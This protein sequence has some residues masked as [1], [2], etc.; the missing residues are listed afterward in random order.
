MFRQYRSILLD[1]YFFL[2][3]CFGLSNVSAIL[4]SSPVEVHG[5]MGDSVT[6]TC[7]FTS[8]SRATSRMSVDWAYRPQSGGPPQAFFHFSSLVFPP[9]DR[10][11][12]GRVQWQGSPARGDATIVLL[13]AT[14]N[15]NGTYTCSVRNP[16]DVHGSP[17]SHTVLTVTPRAVAVRFSDVAVLLAF[18]LLPSAVITMALIGRMFCPLR[19]KNQ[20][21]A[22]R[23][24]IEVMDGDEHVLQPTKTREKNANCCDLYWMDEDEEYYIQKERPREEGMAESHC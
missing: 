1:K 3:I 4:V 16:P 20:S 22:Y 12:K 14:L 19:D 8:T 18:I 2:I 23:S 13:H 11:F 7:T 15:D 5:A 6:L 9:T 10:Q 24:P 17:T 21:H